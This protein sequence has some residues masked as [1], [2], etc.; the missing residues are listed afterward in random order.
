MLKFHTD[1]LAEECMKIMQASD[2]SVMLVRKYTCN[3][4]LGEKMQSLCCEIPVCVLLIIVEMTL[5]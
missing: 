2:D 3:L 4:V 5:L 1:A